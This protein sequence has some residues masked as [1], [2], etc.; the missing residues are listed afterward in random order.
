MSQITSSNENYKK[1]LI[2]ALSCSI[3]WGVLP[4]YW[5]ALRPIESSVIIFYRIF[6]VGVVCFLASLKL[7]GIEGIKEPL[8]AKGAKLK[9]LLA[10][11]LVTANWSI[12]IWAVNA[13][14]VIQ[15]C[16]GYYIEPLMVCL[17]GII[18]FRE[19]LTKYKLTALIFAMA[20]IVVMLVHFMQAPIIALTLA[21]T[22]ATYAALKKSYKLP[23][24]LSLL[25]ETMYLMLPA[26]AVIIYLE[27]TGQGALGVA[28]PGKYMLL[29]F[30]GPLTALALAFFAE[31]ANNVPLVTLGL[32]EYLSPSLSLIIGI[33]LFREPFD[34]IQ[35][36][37]FVIVWIGLVFFTLGEKRD[38]VRIICPDEEDIF[39]FFGDDY[40]RFDF[41]ADIHRVTAGYGGEALLVMGNKKT[42]L[43][44]CGMAYCGEQTVHNIKKLLKSKKRKTLDY[45]FLSHSHYDHM[46]AL[47]YIKSEFPNAVVCGSEHCKN[48]LLRPNARKLIKELGTVARDLYAPESREE[49][50]AN[51]LD[52]DKILKDGDVISLGD[53][54]IRAIETKGHTDCSMSYLL[55]PAGILFTSESTGILIADVNVHTPILKSFADSF[56]SLEKCRNC[57]ARRIC[58]SHFGMLPEDFNNTYWDSFEKALHEKLDYIRDLMDAGLDDEQMLAAYDQKYWSDDREKGQPKEAFTINS[59]H[60]LSAAKK[61]IEENR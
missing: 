42:A 60:I 35:F 51:N 23:A 9:F 15:T 7:Y 46:G 52:V 27:A 2:Y 22:F 36:I 20:G 31:A 21:F 12:Y 19:K 43:I 24:I 53:E 44:D 33:F 28:T 49:I 11:I 32:I 57:G 29:M 38:S 50:P 16:V 56:V 37:A 55:E 54:T 5:Q 6:L 30:C 1:G 26:L 48:I 13:D 3:L 61:Y 59:R 40:D 4:I 39:K 17:F 8:K 41:P 45:V 10:G 58:L 47:P 25:Y 34:S 18:F 14:Y